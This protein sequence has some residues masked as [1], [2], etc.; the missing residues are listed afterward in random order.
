MALAGESFTGRVVAVHDGD[1][2]TVERADGELVRIRLWGIDCPESDQP[3]G[4]RA[5]AFTAEKCLNKTVLVFERDE[6][7]YGRLVAEVML[8]RAGPIGQLRSNLL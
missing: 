6:D 2:I 4:D 1:T 3:W 7:R 5:M 8:A